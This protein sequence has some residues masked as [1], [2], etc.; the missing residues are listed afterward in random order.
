M[1]WAPEWGETLLG[2][3][4]RAPWPPPLNPPL[5]QFIF[6]LK[7]IY[8]RDDRQKYFTMIS[9]FGKTCEKTKFTTSHTKNPRKKCP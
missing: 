8:G 2:A 4:A 7:K 6:G 5:Y 9:V 1:N 3:G